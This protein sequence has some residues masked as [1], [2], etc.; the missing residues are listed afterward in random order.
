MKITGFMV[1]DS[2]GTEIQADAHGNNLAFLCRACTHPV[3][4]V[5]LD[6]Q[7]GSDER[8]PADCKGCGE[9]YFL[10]LR[11]Q[12]NKLYVLAVNEVPD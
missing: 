12:S 1:M 10:S 11:P 8:H 2:S 9:L 6:N 7:R 3:L 5:A 4:A